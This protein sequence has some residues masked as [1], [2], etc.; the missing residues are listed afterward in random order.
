MPFL[1]RGKK[2]LF[3]P[4]WTLYIL[5]YEIRQMDVGGGWKIPRQQECMV[6][7]FC[8]KPLSPFSLMKYYAMFGSL[9]N[10]QTMIPQKGTLFG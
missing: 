7:Y 5:S 10:Q 1:I 2:K 4:P 6:W 9:G 3:I 8:F